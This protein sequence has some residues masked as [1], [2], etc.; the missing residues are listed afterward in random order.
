MAGHL[1]VEDDVGEAW[2]GGDLD[3]VGLR[4]GDRGPAEL[5]LVGTDDLAVPRPDR[6]R[7]SREFG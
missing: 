2:I 4:L 5:D 7:I 1:L 6:E 3:T